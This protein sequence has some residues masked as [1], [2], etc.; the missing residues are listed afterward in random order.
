MTDPKSILGVHGPADPST[1]P[2]ERYEHR[3][4]T[5][6]R[7]VEQL[8]RI[9]DSL[10]SFTWWVLLGAFVIALRGCEAAASQ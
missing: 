8:R 9:A 6:E 10:N 4:P 1:A 3:T 2:R 5:D 7:I